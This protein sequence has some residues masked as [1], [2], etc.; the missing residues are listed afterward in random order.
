[1]KNHIVTKHFGIVRSPSEKYEF[2][3][4]PFL[5]VIKSH[6]KRKAILKFFSC[7]PC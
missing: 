4:A 2:F 3:T 1:M 6:R 5:E 7:D